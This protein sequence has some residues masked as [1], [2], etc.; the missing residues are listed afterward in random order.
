MTIQWEKKCRASSL[1][2]FFSPCVFAGQGPN[3]QLWCEQSSAE[4]K[5]TKAGQH[6]GL[7]NLITCFI[8]RNVFLYH[9]VWGREPSSQAVIYTSLSHCAG[10]SDTTLCGHVHVAFLISRYI[11]SV[12]R[13]GSYTLLFTPGF[14]SRDHLIS[15]FTC[16]AALD[17]ICV[18]T[19][20]CWIEITKGVYSA[21][22]LRLVVVIFK[23]TVIVTVIY[24]NWAINLH[25]VPMFTSL[26][27]Y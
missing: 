2:A 8:C 20:R 23:H 19:V 15:D 4:Q 16:L 17:F 1:S 26:T 5:R 27:V 11:H 22:Q 18:E 21:V 7:H 3:S 6:T 24:C 12:C 13:S 9:S 10:A 14:E 25:S